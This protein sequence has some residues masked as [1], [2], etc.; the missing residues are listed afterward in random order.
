MSRTSARADARW[1]CHHS[2]P[3]SCPRFGSCPPWLRS[4]GQSSAGRVTQPRQQ[5]RRPVGRYWSVGRY[6]PQ[7]WHFPSSR[8]PSELRERAAA[9]SSSKTGR[10]TLHALLSYSREERD[11]SGPALPP[12]RDPLKPISR[13]VLRRAGARCSCVP[14]QSVGSST[15]FD[16]VGHFP[17]ASISTVVSF[18]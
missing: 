18:Q 16:S 15:D 7:P 11:R 4:E 8:S 5:N 17:L 13:I 9:P 3:I 12:T 1:L 2:R 10:S 6:P 14:S